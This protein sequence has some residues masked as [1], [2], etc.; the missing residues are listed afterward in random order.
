MSTK[1]SLNARHWSRALCAWL[2]WGCQ[3]SCE[4]G[5]III[6]I[7]ER[8]LSALSKVELRFEPIAWALDRYIAFI[9]R[10]LTLMD[11]TFFL[12]L[13]HLLSSLLLLISLEV[14][15]AYNNQYKLMSFDICLYLRKH[16]YRSNKKHIHHSLPQFF[17]YLFESASS[18]S[19]PHPQAITDVLSVIG[20][21]YAFSRM[22]SNW[23]PTVCPPFLSAF[24]QSA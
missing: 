3:S 22:I 1:S 24:F 19:L 16:H 7:L 5:S 17:S 2:I 4:V 13:L 18:P 15:L 11:F 9:F 10:L 12:L 14:Q 23:N 20:E 21:Q 8:E 6:C